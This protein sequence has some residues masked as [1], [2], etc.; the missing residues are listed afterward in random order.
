MREQIIELIEK[1]M[2]E[3]K[4][5]ELLVSTNLI[6][7]LKESGAYDDE[8][9]IIAKHNKMF[10]M[11]LD[12]LKESDDSLT[13]MLQV[14]PDLKSNIDPGK[15]R[16]VCHIVEEANEASKSFADY[17]YVVE[18]TTLDKEIKEFARLRWLEEMVDTLAV[19]I[20]CIKRNFTPEEFSESVSNVIEKN[21][22]RGYYKEGDNYGKD[23]A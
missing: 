18:H 4:E 10:D 23:V 9:D 1:A 7:K 13:F 22:T 15:Y 12:A 6:G 11:V 14:F 3:S 19:T 2:I 20:S 17:E 8:D 16:Q 5:N 21:R